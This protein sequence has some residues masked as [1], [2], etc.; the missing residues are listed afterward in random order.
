V[1]ILL[2]LFAL[3]ATGLFLLATAVM[4]LTFRRARRVTAVG[5]LVPALLSLA[6]LALYC[7]LLGAAPST[8]MFLVAFA[9]GGA[10]GSAW[11]RTHRLFRGRDGAVRSQANIW[12][13]AVW[14][15]VLA[16]NQFAVLAA[17]RSSRVLVGLLVLS[18]GIAVGN[19]LVLL[20]RLHRLPASVL[21]VAL[22]AAGSAGADDVLLL[23]PRN[24]DVTPIGGWGERGGSG[25]D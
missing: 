19:A 18:T 11:A 1:D 17:G 6:I 10:L 20:G 7:V 12:Y 14:A 2:R 22:L 16:L 4:L 8:A 3:A 24:F 25:R 23:L 15:A 21:G 13:L 9:T 5:L